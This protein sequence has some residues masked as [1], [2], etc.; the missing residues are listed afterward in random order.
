[1]IKTILVLATVFLV[2]QGADYCLKEAE[3]NDDQFFDAVDEYFKGTKRP[4]RTVSVEC[5][6]P[7]DNSTCLY[8]VDRMGFHRDGTWFVARFLT[9]VPSLTKGFL[10]VSKL[11]KPF[12][13]TKRTADTSIWKVDVGTMDVLTPNAI[14][15]ATM[16][17]TGHFPL[18][19]D[20]EA[21]LTFLGV[22]TGGLMS[23]LGH[24]FRNFDLTG[25]D[26]DP[27]SEYL[28][29]KWFGYE[30]LPNSR[31]L[32]GDGA[33]LIKKMAENSETSDAVLIDACHNMEPPDGIFCPVESLRTPEFLKS[34]SK[35]IGMN[36]MTTFNLYN[37][38]ASNGSYQKVLEEFRRYFTECNL[39]E[40]FIGNVFIT[41]FNNRIRN[42]K[43]DV[44]ET[45]AFLKKQ[46]IETFLKNVM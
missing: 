46:R 36:G 35:V 45:D 33:L 16:F 13:K 23:Y 38:K 20:I 14:E 40:N 25:I 6:D 44:K 3:L 10:S 30:P 32:I 19:L 17:T 21:N 37:H 1:M 18:N 26:I 11:Q 34:L 4:Q 41:C 22:A 5:P 24:Y 39:I 27:E 9:P 2:I 29:R 15:F 42:Y 12:F 7:K 31:I 28:A 43:V 8:I